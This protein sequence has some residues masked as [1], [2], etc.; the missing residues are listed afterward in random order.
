[1]ETDLYLL[2]LKS[3]LK[4][5]SVSAIGGKVVSL[6]EDEKVYG[7]HGISISEFEVLFS[8][9]CSPVLSKANC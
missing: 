2:Y 8:S 4:V 7:T 1:M 6:D 5:V 3:K 9:I